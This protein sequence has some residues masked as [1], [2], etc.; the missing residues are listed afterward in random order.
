MDTPLGPE[1]SQD[2]PDLSLLDVISLHEHLLDLGATLDLPRLH[3]EILQTCVA[4]MAADKGNLQVFDHATGMLSIVAQI[5]FEPEFLQTFARITAEDENH[6][7]CSR[8][9]VRRQRAMSGDLRNETEFAA[10]REAA[11]TAGFRSVQSTPVFSSAG[12]L[13]AVVSTHWC[14]PHQPTD[15]QIA[16]MDR[17]LRQAAHF[18]ERRANDDAR[19][20]ALAHE[21]SARQ[22][23]EDLSRGK[24]RFI[25]TLA[26][27]MRQPLAPMIA[28]LE[29]MKL[30]ISREKGERARHIVERQVAQLVRLVEDLVDAARINE[31]KARL[32]NDS[33][34][35]TKIVTDAI[36][37]VE[38]SAR[39][40]RQRIELTAAA[41]ETWVNVDASRIQ[42]VF[43]NLL[44]NA[45]KFSSED[46]VIAVRVTC[47][48]ANVRVDVHDRGRGIPADAMPYIFEMFRQSSDGE[49]GGLGIGL[50]VVRGLVELHGGTVE[51]H[52]PGLGLGSTFVVRLPAV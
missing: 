21:R 17:F 1:S 42:Q 19:D 40:K 9:V 36:E 2:A 48:G 49:E 15:C 33:V 5:G 47:E 14:E 11:T 8:A 20:G 45:S 13:L 46:A 10:V 32:R 35:L 30:R 27:E 41:G 52:S 6:S 51:A 29:L 34:D 39:T 31:G 22:A 3:A 24:D 25:A 28:A 26:H 7:V 23:A 37:V 16:T 4:L 43:V 50:S 38:A 44:S 12:E 18:L